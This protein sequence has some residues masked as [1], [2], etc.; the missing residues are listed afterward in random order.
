MKED[1]KGKNV[2]VIGLAR[3]GVSAALALKSQGANV[4][5]T[6][7]GKPDAEKVCPMEEAGIVFETGGHTPRAFEADLAILSPGVPVTSKI[8]MEMRQKK[9]RVISEIELAY[10]LTDADIIGITGSNGKSTTTALLGE[11][12]KSG[13]FQLRVGGNIGDALSGE[14]SGMNKGDVFVAEISS[15]QLDTAEKFRPNAAAILNL[16]PDHLDRYPSADDYYASKIS[17][18]KNQTPEDLLVLNDD[19]PVS[20]RKKSG[21]K[22]KAKIAT[23]SLDKE[24]RQGAFVRGNDIVI[25]NERGEKKIAKADQ[26][27]LIGKHNLA[28]IL[29]AVIIADRYGISAESIRETLRSFKGIEHRIEFVRTLNGVT[30]YNDSKGTNVD[31]VRWALLG[32]KAGIHLIAGGRDKAGDFTSLNDL[33]REKVKSVHAIGE[34]AG[35]VQKAWQEITEMHMNSSMEDAVKSAFLA[36]KSGD[37][38]LLYPACASFDMYKNYEERGRH[39]KS[40]VEAL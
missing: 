37:V 29:A 32:I 22:T 26:V 33:V 5:G 23:F 7:A 30:F 18:T 10:L 36:S 27:G 8:V 21:I 34:A 11:L 35:K 17:I 4:F 3:S 24:V 40:I 13:K 25:R 16:T 20:I 38:V 39:F 9:I 12:L 2:T 6:D 31:S 19:D 15:F 14:L 1:F 28:N